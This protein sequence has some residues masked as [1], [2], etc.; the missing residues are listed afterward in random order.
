[1]AYATRA[2][3]E[4][5]WG[6]EFVA[7]ILPEGV[8]A[9]AAIASALAMASNEIDTYL[10]ARYSLPLAG[11]PRVLVSPAADIAIYKLANRH[12]ALTTTIEDRYKFAIALLE[13]IADGKAGLGADE[14]GVASDPGASSGGAYFDANRRMFSRRTLP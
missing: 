11:N 7:D 3:I 14:P 6:G 1:M 8:D 13:R 2:D 5:I 4:E 10:S 12:T 9:D